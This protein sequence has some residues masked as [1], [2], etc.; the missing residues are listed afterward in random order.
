MVA[1]NYHNVRSSLYAFPIFLGLLFLCIVRPSQVLGQGIRD[2]IFDKKVTLPK[3]RTTVYQALNQLTDSIGYLFAY[4]SKLV[5]SDRRIRTNITSIPLR[6]ALGQILADSTLGFRVIDRHILIFTNTRVDTLL[7]GRESPDTTRFYSVSGRVLDSQ[8]RKPLSYVTVGIPEIALGSVTN[9]EGAFMLK[10][11]RGFNVS[12]LSISHIGYRKMAVP[13]DLLRLEPVD[14]FLETDYIS[15]QEVIIRNIDPRM[16][17]REALSK[18]SDN[19]SPSPTY[20]TAFYREG[21]VKS[22]KFQNYSEAIFKIYKSAYSKKIETDQV[23]L[24]KSRKTQNLEP[25][26]TLSIKLRGGINSSLTLDIVKNIPF[27]LEDDYA[28]FYTFTRKDIVTVGD[29]IAYAIAFDQKEFSTEPLIIGTLYIDVDNLAIL[30]ADLEINP[31]NVV[32]ATDQFVH[33]RNRRFRFKPEGIKYSVRYTN[34][35]GVYHLSHVRGDLNFKYRLRRSFS[36]NSFHLFFELA[37]TQIDSL[38]VS[39]FARNEIE[40]T[41]NIFLENAYEYDQVFWR[42]LNIIPPEKIVFEALKDINLKIEEIQH[43][44]NP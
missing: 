18:I 12:H 20:H 33:K 11:D 21:V 6:K 23:K 19:F 37:T 41:Q 39:R 24:L 43:N 2:E 30:G 26:D 25:T 13:I 9:Q 4:D 42:D 27:Y 15:I 16:L 28:E 17:V 7:L 36:L 34:L 14:I 40:S 5:D 3:Q 38:N 32:R 8:T 29:R 10:I 1:S 35:N 44:S 31:K 22:G